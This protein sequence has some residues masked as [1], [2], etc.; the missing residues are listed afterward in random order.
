[1]TPTYEDTQLVELGWLDGDRA[2]AALEAWL[3]DCTNGPRFGPKLVGLAASDGGEAFLAEGLTGLAKLLRATDRDLLIVDACGLS[4]R[5][6]STFDRRI[7]RRSR[8]ADLF[9]AS[10][11]IEIVALSDVVSTGAPP[12]AAALRKT[13]DLLAADSDLVFVALPDIAEWPAAVSLLVAADEI[14]LLRDENDQAAAS[15]P[16][17]EAAEALGLALT[18]EIRMTPG[19]VDQPN[20]S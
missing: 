5:L 17:I 13:L 1:M 6:A 2:D 9:G 11:R 12:A 19:N 4:D 10:A 7:G 18:G 20:R 3:D 15:D 16:A 14:V 8:G